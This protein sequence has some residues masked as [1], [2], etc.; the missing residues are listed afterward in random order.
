[1]AA[2]VNKKQLYQKR[3]GAKEGGKKNPVPHFAMQMVLGLNKLPD[4]EWRMN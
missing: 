4:E 1:M 2:T 3:L